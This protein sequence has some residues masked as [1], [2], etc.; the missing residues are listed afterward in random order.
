M[1]QIKVYDDNKRVGNFFLMVENRSYGLV[2]SLENKSV[3]MKK[4][5]FFLLLVSA[6]LF[7]VS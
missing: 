4:K 1:P 6:R 2:T 5:G 3:H 7:D